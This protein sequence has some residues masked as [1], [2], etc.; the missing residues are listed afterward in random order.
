MRIVSCPGFS[1]V[2][3][4]VIMTPS[5]RRLIDLLYLVQVS[6]CAGCKS[7]CCRQTVAL[8]CIVFWIVSCTLLKTV[9]QPIQVVSLRLRNRDTDSARI[10]LQKRWTSPSALQKCCGKGDARTSA[11]S[12]KTRYSPLMKSRAPK[13]RPAYAFPKAV[14]LQCFCDKLGILVFGAGCKKAST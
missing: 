8:R 4:F 7:G 14:P 5:P 13:E 9:Q 12:R 2:Q 3:H 11:H 6:C 10:H 1:S